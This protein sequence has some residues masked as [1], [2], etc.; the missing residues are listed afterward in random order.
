MRQS[1]ISA[2]L[3]A[4][5]LEQEEAAAIAIKKLQDSER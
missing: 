4:V 2:N 3:Q 5:N 1:I